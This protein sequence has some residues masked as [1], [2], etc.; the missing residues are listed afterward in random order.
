MLPR[1]R[2]GGRG[3][4]AERVCGSFFELKLCRLSQRMG[5]RFPCPWRGRICVL[6]L[7]FLCRGMCSIH[8]EIEGCAE[9]MMLTSPC[10]C[11]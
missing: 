3:V 6:E 9:L 11:L 8:R 1:L 4:D 7:V 2:W 10:S 5:R